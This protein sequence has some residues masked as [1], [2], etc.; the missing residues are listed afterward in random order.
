MNKQSVLIGIMI[1]IA[2]VS[3]TLAVVFFFKFNEKS[4]PS[5]SAQT[6]SSVDKDGR[7]VPS[8]YERNEVKNT[9]IKNSGQAQ[10][11]YNLYLEKTPGIANGDIKIDWQIS[12]A[13]KALTPSIVQS[14]FAN[15]DFEK[16]LLDTIASWN[17][18]PPPSKESFYVAHL[19]K[20]NKKE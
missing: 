15:P 8:P 10:T 2:A 6:Q 3:T 9:I 19:F 18:P 13:G 17:F 12:P 1:I 11:C 20:F 14:K 7:P 4:P 16:C 5:V